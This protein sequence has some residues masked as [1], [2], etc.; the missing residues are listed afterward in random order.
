MNFAPARIAACVQLV[1]LAAIAVHAVGASPAHA[2]SAIKTYRQA[3][4]TVSASL[5]AHGGLAPLRDAGGVVIRTNG[6][7]DLATRL[8]GRSPARAEPTPIAETIAVDLAGG[9]V[10]SDLEW[11]NYKFSRQ[12]LREIYDAEGR[13]LYIDKRARSGGWPPIATAPDAR[14]RYQ[15]ILPQFMLADAL[16][17]RATLRGMGESSLAGRTV[18][19]VGFV[20]TAGDHMTLYIDRR[21]RHLRAAA[22]VFDMEL[23]GDVE[24][25]WEWSDYA[26]KTG[27]VVPGRLRVFLDRALLK[28]VKL[29]V[30]PGTGGDSFTA[31]DDIEVGEPPPVDELPSFADF[32]P[33]SKRPG[34]A[35]EVAPGVYLAPGVRPGFHMFFVEF[36]EFVLAVDAPTGWYEM[37]QIPPY[38]FARG[39][40][41][42]DLAEK[43]IR[44]IKSTV[45][46]KPIRYV[47]LTHHHSDHI[48]GVRAFIAEGATIL[49]GEAAAGAAR[50]AA[51]RPHSLWPD[52]LTAAGTGTQIEV[53]RGT[54]TISD[55]EMEVELIELPADNPKAGGFLVVHL[56]RQKI[57]YFTS[58]IYPLPEASFPAPESL[59]L[60]L[61]FVKWLDQSGLEP[62]QI[63]NVHGQARVQDWQ[64][65]RFREMLRNGAPVAGEGVTDES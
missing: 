44:T 45:A 41:T 15:R 36:S 29:S 30:E 37:Q 42:S 59:P 23:L 25:R 35:R 3:H 22:H 57:M 39:E 40:G 33:Y 27:L 61:W 62:Q 54:R 9:R 60:S 5:V 20:T 64:L 49:A 14:L 16:E 26:D 24:I 17:N 63:F 48:G 50:T 52:R 8:Q 46:G 1:I 2:A 31:P 55:G 28:D 19:V 47:A 56:P 51:G 18:D 38:D 58:F 10:A 7:F 32:T 6:S 43:Y 34:Q 4:E 11:S 12:S 21:N 53:V 65:D 13:V